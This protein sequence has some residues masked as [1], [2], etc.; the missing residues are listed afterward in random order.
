MTLRLNS[1]GGG[2]VEQDA[3]N[4]AGNYSLTLPTSAGSADQYL[5]NT[6]TPGTLEFGDLPTLG[7]TSSATTNTTSGSS[8]TIAGLSTSATLHM[9]SISGVSSDTSTP[10]LL[11][12]VGNG[13]LSTSG[14]FWSIGYLGGTSQYTSVSNTSVRVTHTAFSANSNTY[15]GVIYICCDGTGVVTGNWML[16]NDGGSA[17]FGAF[18]WTGGAAIDRFS[19]QT[20]GTFDAGSFKIHSR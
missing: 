10:Q 6:S 2:Y 19:L 4:I 16:A 17:P 1:S 11:F 20:A 7:F 5:R 14:Y 12:Q 8:H 18:K 9:V 13:S 15:H 3:P